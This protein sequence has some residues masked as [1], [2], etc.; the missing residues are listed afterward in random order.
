VELEEARS[1]LEVDASS[2]ATAMRRAYLQAIEKTSAEGDP[3]HAQRIEEA[4]ELASRFA[5]DAPIEPPVPEEAPRADARPSVTTQSWSAPALIVS[6]VAIAVL[7]VIL[8]NYASF[9]GEP[10]ERAPDPDAQ[11][12]CAS[13]EIACPHA[14]RVAQAIEDDDCAIGRWP[15]SQLRER[16]APES[17]V[18]PSLA[19]R[20]A[21]ERLLARYVRRCEAP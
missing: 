1:L 12:V 6:I 21:I 2:D 18:P 13:S 14:E 7:F 17:P 10:I 5:G 11:I 8:R 15:A 9:S 20:S 4:Y 16:I 19:T 3:E